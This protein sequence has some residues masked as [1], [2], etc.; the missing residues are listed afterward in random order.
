MNR[1][2]HVVACC[3]LAMGLLGLAR[4]WGQ[5]ESEDAGRRAPAPALVELVLPPA[6]GKQAAVVSQY[7][8]S[9][10]RMG[11]PHA[12]G[13]STILLPGGIRLN[14]H[15]GQVTTV[16]AGSDEE[17]RVLINPLPASAE[18]K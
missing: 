4:T 14:I 17:H 8:V 2:W 12:S 10:A 9:D 3:A 15:Q 13:N 7:M 18:R 1:V 16:R 11:K 5:A 6:L